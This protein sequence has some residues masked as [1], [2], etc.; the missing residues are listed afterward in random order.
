[1]QWSSAVLG[2]VHD[3]LME[4]KQGE[5]SST[6]LSVSELEGSCEKALIRESLDSL[7]SIYQCALQ[8][9]S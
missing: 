3:W 7:Q 6:R 9:G 2:T 4:A 5:G 1:M 8:G